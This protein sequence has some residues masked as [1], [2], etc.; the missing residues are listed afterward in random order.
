ME[1]LRRFMEERKDKK[2]IDVLE[3]IK[4][5]EDVVAY[6]RTGTKERFTQT[7][8][9]GATDEQYNYVEERR[10]NQGL[11]RAAFMR[12]L[13]GR[14]MDDYKGVTKIIKETVQMVAPPAISVGPPP[15]PVPGSEG[16][17]EWQMAHE[18]WKEKMK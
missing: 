6:R 15:P 5:M 14:D 2:V 13:I 7:I 8:S 1:R 18:K 17:D 11:S 10:K 9:F 12:S 4:S 3:Q 16:E